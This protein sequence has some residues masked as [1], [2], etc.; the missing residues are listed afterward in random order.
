M[1]AL[2]LFLF[3]AP[4]VQDPQVLDARIDSVTVYPSSA[5][6]HR[7]SE[8]ITADGNFV[9]AGLTN[10]LDRSR[11]R[12]KCEDGEI[13]RVEVLERLQ[14]EITDEE[15]AALVAQL[16]AAQRELQTASDRG[17]LNDAMSKHLTE[18]FARE[19]ESSAR[20][21][22]EGQAPTE[23]WEASFEFL[24]RRTEEVL[25]VKR[26]LGWEIDE[27]REAI[28]KLEHQ[29]GDARRGALRPVVD[30]LVETAGVSA[31]GA[32]V[33]VEYVVH[34]AGWSPVYDLRAASDAE[35]VRLVYRAE[36]FQKTLE[37]WNEVELLLSTAQPHLGAQ[38]PDPETSWVDVFEPAPQRF[39]GRKG[40]GVGGPASPGAEMAA[41]GYAEA[42]FVEES[43]ESYA[44]THAAVE[45]EGLSLRYRIA[46]NETVES[47]NEP[48][49]VLVGQADLE[50]EPEYYC[51]PA[52][53]P[54]VWLRGIATNTSQW[55]LLPGR[56]AVFFGADYLGDS[57]LGMVQVD[58][59]LTLHLG[60]APM[61]S[62]ERTQ[63]E[64]VEEEPGFLSSTMSQ[65]R[66]WRVHFENHGSAVSAADGSVSVIVREAV[67]VSKD[68]R[69]KVDLARNEP[70]HSKDERWEQ[71]REESGI[72]TWELSVPANESADLVYSVEIS[73][74]T[75]LQITGW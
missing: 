8:T 3:A 46:R 12:V 10:D 31:S 75:E 23:A 62:V 2:A 24:S 68:S 61:I 33:E 71:D 20:N 51:A 22:T 72:Y 30:V 36:V 43:A 73:Y 7:S 44:W 32:K 13:V 18:L 38:G 57:N 47:R 42:D 65:R 4:L 50:A 14:K 49:L 11:V 54:T 29:I 9:I 63:F 56:A 48:T 5:H 67:P 66:S 21:L 69:L 60:A 15:L 19:Q 53:D 1:Q 41:L 16:E 28:A 58:E 27:R 64:D 52:L 55:T 17:K 35:S 39:G 70:V 45:S 34:R 26:E 37:D 40:G 59:E 6:V 74:P 25:K